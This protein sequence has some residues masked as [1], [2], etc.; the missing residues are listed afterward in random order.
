MKQNAWYEI[1]I[2][3]PVIASDQRE[4]GNLMRLLR[5]PTA[6]GVLAMTKKPVS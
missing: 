5:P 4:R 3:P 6:V 2:F 1:T